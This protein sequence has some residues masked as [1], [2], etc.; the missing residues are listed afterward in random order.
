MNLG[1]LSDAAKIVAQSMDADIAY[2]LFSASAE[3]ILGHRTE[4]PVLHG[5]S[6][7]LRVQVRR[8]R[9]Y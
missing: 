6:Q 2:Q 7:T 8:S 5:L 9:H 3:L 1:T 4:F